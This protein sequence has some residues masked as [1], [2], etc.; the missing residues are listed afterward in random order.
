[1]PKPQQDKGREYLAIK[2]FWDCVMSKRFTDLAVALRVIAYG[3]KNYDGN[4]KKLEKIFAD[5]VEKTGLPAE[6]LNKYYLLS[7]VKPLKRG[8]IFKDLDTR[9][10][11]LDFQTMGRELLAEPI[12]ALGVDILKTGGFSP[13][14][15][16][17][18]MPLKATVSDK[19][20]FTD[21]AGR[22]GNTNAETNH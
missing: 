12:T 14:D 5:C 2:T 21:N 13:A 17:S 8:I 7:F 1:M 3:Q 16:L 15:I 18:R 11:F 9:Y 10:S 22:N 6:I 4:M 20:L 19:E